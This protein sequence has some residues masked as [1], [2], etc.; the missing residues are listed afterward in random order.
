[1]LRASIEK[2]N[3]FS[4]TELLAAVAVI[5]VVATVIVVRSTAGASASKA[6]ACEVIQGDIEIQCE[7]WR[8]NTG[9]WPNTNL[10]DIGASIHYFPAGLPLCPTDGSG[11]SIDASGQVVGHNH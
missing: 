7:L 1:M 4:L 11:Y 2:T 3:G 9:A 6:A 5:A 8:H 10:S